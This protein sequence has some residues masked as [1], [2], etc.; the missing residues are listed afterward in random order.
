MRGG[1]GHVGEDSN[2]RALT[3]KMLDQK[4]NRRV[5]EDAEDSAEKINPI[6]IER[7]SK[8]GVQPP[9]QPSPWVHGEGEHILPKCHAFKQWAVTTGSAAG[10][11][12]SRREEGIAEFAEDGAAEFGE[13]D[14][15]GEMPDELVVADAAAGLGETAAAQKAGEIGGIEKKGAGLEFLAKE[16]VSP[17]EIELAD[18]HGGD[19]G[20]EKEQCGRFVIHRQQIP[21][22]SLQ[23][24]IKAVIVAVEYWC[25]TAA[26]GT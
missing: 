6:G 18:L 11:I 7:T 26:E 5:A 4:C 14:F 1:R 24:K 2:R 20:Q 16:A 3:R 8:T 10:R 19:G 17:G 23:K 13:V 12:A 15:A 21:A 25:Q 22:V 9:P